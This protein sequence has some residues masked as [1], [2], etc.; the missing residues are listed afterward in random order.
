[1][2]DL[3][4]EHGVGQS[5]NFKHECSMSA[6]DR[7]QVLLV[8]GDLAQ[9]R[10]QVSWLSADGFDV[11]ATD[12]EH[13]AI[14][15]IRE[16]CPN[17][18]IVDWDTQD[19]NALELCH[20]VRENCLQRYVYTVFLTSR[21]DAQEVLQALKECADDF[22]TKPVQKGELLARLHAG[23]RILERE[24]R[25]SKLAKS[26]PLTGLPT[27]R[28]LYELIEREWS[29][30][31]R[32][33]LPMSCV[34][35][36]LDFFKRV[37]DTYGHSFGNEVLCSIAKILKD[38]CRTSDIVTRYGGE[39]FC[40]LLPETDERNALIWAEQVRETIANTYIAIDNKKVRVTASC[41]IAGLLEDLKSPEQLVDL[42]DQALLVAKQSGRDRVV[43]FQA[44]NDSSILRSHAEQGPSALFRGV[45][46]RDVMTTVVA[47][48]NWEDD[49]W[50]ASQF[51]LR[52]RIGSAPVVNNEGKLVGIISETDLMSIMLWPD[53]WSTKIKDVMKTNVV[54]YEEDAPVLA[55]YEFLC[56]VAIRRVIVVDED[57]P[58]G[59]ISR[60]SLL[61][62]FCNSLK[63]QNVY[64]PSDEEGAGEP[65]IG[66]SRD[67]F[68]ETVIDLTR[69]TAL[70][71]S[72]LREDDSDVLPCLIG[73]VSRIEELVNDLLALSGYVN[74]HETLASAP[75]TD[76]LS[77]LQTAGVGNLKAHLESAISPGN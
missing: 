38:N 49:L 58:T 6:P 20:R 46:A 27:Q 52:F 1:M 16:D 22:L 76:E 64:R 57:R 68:L 5:R 23:R 36:D 61:R 34:M 17:F 35:I 73:G 11:I 51:F 69:E 3:C 45:R 77:R 9:R 55:I 59:V 2:V 30:A 19:I 54:F 72:S 29:R 53:W 7:P 41:G 44:V 48:L 10:K 63:A 39:E 74:R 4:S 26:D 62:W 65:K 75:D 31:R 47:G 24:S 37:N 66:N 13:E 28:T 42:A 15:T 33:Q 70:M 50:C 71:E 18:L 21:G 25:L 67:R 40:A 56:R 32:Y 60:S 14:T 43:P 8:N 12:D